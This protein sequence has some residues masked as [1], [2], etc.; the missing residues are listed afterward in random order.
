MLHMSSSYLLLLI[1]F[2]L[3]ECISMDKRLLYILII[4]LFAT[5]RPKIIFQVDKLDG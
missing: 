2:E 3:G 1:H 4:I 5:L